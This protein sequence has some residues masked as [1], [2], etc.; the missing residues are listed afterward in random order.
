VED[1]DS[2]KVW[3]GQV[4]DWCRQGGGE[5]SGAPLG[6]AAQ[7]VYPPA[8][9]GEKQKP[10]IE[11]EEVSAGQPGPKKSIP[12]AEANILVRAHLNKNPNATVKEVHEATGVSMGGIAQSAAWKANQARKKGGEL[13]PGRKGKT[14]Q[15][16]DKMLQA[17]GQDADPAARITAEEVAWQNLLEKATPEERARLHAMKPAERAKLIHTYLEQLTDQPDDEE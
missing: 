5:G 8:Q 13:T 3:L 10:A 4:I 11:Q 6:Q 1:R 12:G 14:I 15:L 7:P 2:F 9:P 17:R 16:T